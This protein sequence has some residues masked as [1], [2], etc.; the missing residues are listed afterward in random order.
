M[1]WLKLTVLQREQLA[2]LGQTAPVSHIEPVRDAAGNYWINSDLRGDLQNYGH[3]A[4]F[5]AQAFTTQ[6]SDP[7]W[8]SSD[9]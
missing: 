9:V 4:D 2:T 6:A 3:Y 8:P 1:S 5:L 7:V